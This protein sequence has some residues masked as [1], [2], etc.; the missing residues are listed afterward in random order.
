MKK[1]SL[2]SL[3]LLTALLIGCQQKGNQ[4]L[5]DEVMKVHDE[6]MP[7]MNDIHKAKQQLKNEIANTPDITEA[8]KTE[9]ETIIVKLD[10]ANEGMMIWMREFNPPPDSKGVEQ[11]RDYLKKEKEKVEK[12]KKDI[13][14]ALEKAKGLTKEK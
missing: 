9:L 3:L 12:V 5:Y 8:R 2:K 7:K 1:Q 11:A 14:E 10:S 6:V 13:T 4:E